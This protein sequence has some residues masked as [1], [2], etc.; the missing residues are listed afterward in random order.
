MDR[1]KG[2]KEYVEC[3]RFRKALGLP[4][5]VE[6]Q[7]YFLAQGEY[8]INYQF[9]HPVSG[10][11][12]LLRVNCGSQMHLE[13]QI[14]Y[15]YRALKLLEKSGRT[16]QVYYVDG[17]RKQMNYGVMVMEFLPGAALNYR[18][19]LSL[20]AECLAD[21]HSV[22]LDG[23]SGL[24]A[25]K[26]PL[27]AI[28]DECEE[29]FR[30]YW[31]SPFA[32]DE[33]KKKIRRMLDE[34]W[35]KIQ[36]AD[37]ENIYRCCINTELN[38]TNFLING[39]GYPNYL[40]D[41]EKPVYGDPAQDLAHF[42]APTTT[43]WKTDVILSRQEREQ[44]INEYMEKANR[45]ISVNG[46]KE[47]TEIYIPVTCLRGVTWCAMAWVQY[48]QPDKLIFNESTFRKLEAYLEDSFLENLAN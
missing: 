16:P 15:E 43:F 11:K 27:K 29:M 8:N 31:N 48:R 21:I 20:A 45:R 24:I 3:E 18:T 7:Y 38:S 2:L 22:K 30:V 14:E 35:K 42:L 17:N 37:M 19:D 28:L 26:L 32:Q 34:G 36:T 41:W 47:R 39:A 4:D 33:K 25:P 23:A 1:I 5:V 13:N 44:F 40:I 12:L 10:K 9:I 6:E 46:L